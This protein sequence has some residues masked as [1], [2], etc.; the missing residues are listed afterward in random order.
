[1]LVGGGVV[2]Q[3]VPQMLAAAAV[4][5]SSVNIAGGFRITH[6]RLSFLLCGVA[7]MIVCQR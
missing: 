3:T 1:M 6:V 2:P 7:A 5:F 4:G